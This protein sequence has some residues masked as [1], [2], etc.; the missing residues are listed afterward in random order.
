MKNDFYD[1]FDY[2]RYKYDLSDRACNIH[3]TINV[4]LNFIAVIGLSIIAF[5]Y[6]FSIL[7]YIIFMIIGFV[8]FDMFLLL[9]EKIILTNKRFWDKIKYSFKLL[10]F[11]KLNMEE[12]LKIIKEKENERKSF[13]KKSKG[14]SYYEEELEEIDEELKYYK[15]NLKT[16]KEEDVI[17]E[18]AITKRYL[19]DISYA[20]KILEALNLEKQKYSKDIQEEFNNIIELSKEL[21]S[22]CKN[23][24]ILIGQLMKTFNIYLVELIDIFNSY[25]KLDNEEKEKNLPKVKLIFKELN[26]HLNELKIKI[27]CDSNKKFNNN[28]DFLLQSLKETKKK[29]DNDV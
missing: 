22:I 14:T 24:P 27:Q 11:K 16:I 9:F 19:N 13:E 10:K 1:Y 8:V 5:I 3:E 2:I 21:I 25:S 23:E 28:A 7:N 6:K 29:E 17:I 20:E 26:N 15:D 4:I 18:D 12:Q